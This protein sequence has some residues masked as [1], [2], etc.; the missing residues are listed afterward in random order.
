MNVRTYKR[1][2]ERKNENYI[3]PHAS[4]VGGIIMYTPVNPS[5]DYKSLQYVMIF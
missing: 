5:F 1:T 4:Y 3:P 2:D